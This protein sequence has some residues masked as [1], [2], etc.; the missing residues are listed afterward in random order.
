MNYASYVPILRLSKDIEKILSF[1]SEIHPDLPRRFRNLLAEKFDELDKNPER[2]SP[3]SN[4]IRAI[5]MKL[6]KR[7]TVLL[8][9]PFL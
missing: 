4:G 6:S 8:F 1:L 3:L 7:L 2:W 5:R 9:L